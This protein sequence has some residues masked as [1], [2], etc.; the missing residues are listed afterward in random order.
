VDEF[1]AIVAMISQFL[2]K[3]RR[4]NFFRSLI[5]STFPGRRAFL[6]KK[7]GAARNFLAAHGW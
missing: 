3:N 2:L 1:D 7:E 5:I 6:Q 4:N